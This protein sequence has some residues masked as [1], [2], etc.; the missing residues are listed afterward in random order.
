MTEKKQ[1]D[2]DNPK[3]APHPADAS[4]KQI[5]VMIDPAAPFTNLSLGAQV[6]QHDSE[7]NALRAMA[8]TPPSAQHAERVATEALA[9][10][11]DPA[12]K[13][14]LTVPATEQ[15]D[16]DGQPTTVYDKEGNV[17]HD[18]SA[19]RAEGPGSADAKKASEKKTADTKK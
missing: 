15:F 16:E 4:G 10:S 2:R 9:A 14:I 19:R 13:S 11:H 6:A 3:L 12:K 7:N 18:T 5:P 1:S 8:F 17:K